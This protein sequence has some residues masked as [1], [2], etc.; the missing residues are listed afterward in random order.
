MYYSLQNSIHGQTKSFWETLLFRCSNTLTLSCIAAN[1]SLQQK[2][3]RVKN[4]QIVLKYIHTL[5]TFKLRLHIKIYLYNI[6]V[7]NVFT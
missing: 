6:D 3:K 1:I 5:I 7:S 2:K 4:T